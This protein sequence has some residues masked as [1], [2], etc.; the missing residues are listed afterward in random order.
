MHTATGCRR[1]SRPP[2]LDL[3]QADEGSRLGPELTEVGDALHA[4]LSGPCSSSPSRPLCAHSAQT[5]R[6]PPAFYRHLLAGE[7]C[8]LDSLPPDVRHMR[9]M[10][11]FYP[12][13][14]APYPPAPPPLPVPPP[15]V[16]SSHEA[17]PLPVATEGTDMAPAP[18]SASPAS[19]VVAV[20]START[21]TTSNI[22]LKAPVEVQANG[23]TASISSAS[24]LATV[25][26]SAIAAVT[27]SATD[28]R[29]HI[30]AAPHV[31]TPSATPAPVLGGTLTHAYSNGFALT[32]T[33]GT[34]AAGTSCG[35]GRIATAAGAAEPKSCGDTARHTSAADL[36]SLL[37]RETTSEVA[38]CDAAVLSQVQSTYTHAHRYAHS[39]VLHG[40]GPAQHGTPPSRFCPLALPSLPTPAAL[41]LR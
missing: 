14:S 20:P 6:R 1:V 17:A 13:R 40:D 10:D 33:G 11:P 5:V 15:V 23:A 24:P 41:R 8:P 22:S 32:A 30:S 3:D 37:A 34:A 12:H 27:S 21:P 35:D 19:P 2:A 18:T 9:R 16:Q 29:P 26:A 7:L 36:T 25:V 39:R 38:D 31:L 4:L 28:F